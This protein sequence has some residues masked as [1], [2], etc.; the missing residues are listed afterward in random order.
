MSVWYLV[1]YADN[2]DGG[3]VLEAVQFGYTE[4]DTH[5]NLTYLTGED[6]SSVFPGM[7]MYV[8]NVTCVAVQLPTVC[9]EQIIS[10]NAKRKYMAKIRIIFSCT[11]AIW[12]F[13]W[14]AR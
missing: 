8:T 13:C 1:N 5:F 11:L 6:D 4:S 12:W 9:Y 3:N 14:R 2:T 10:H 7:H